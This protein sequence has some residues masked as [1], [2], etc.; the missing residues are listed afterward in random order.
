MAVNFKVV[1]KKF[2]CSKANP[3]EP[4]VTLSPADQ[5]SLSISTGRAV[6]LPAQLEPGAFEE[7]L[8]LVLEDLPFLAGR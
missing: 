2:L 1:T 8:Q 5:T 6:F 7:C 3:K 4:T